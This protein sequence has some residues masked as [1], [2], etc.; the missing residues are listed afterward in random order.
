MSK[1]QIVIIVITVL[2]AIISA[3]ACAFGIPY[4]EVDTTQ[5]EEMLTDTEVQSKLTF[6]HQWQKILRA[7]RLSGVLFRR[8]C[9]E[10]TYL[11]ARTS[12]RPEI[13]PE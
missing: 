12:R 3:I 2:S 5:V 13:R 9:F 1:K 4:P 10:D 6:L 11:Q 8:S 7:S